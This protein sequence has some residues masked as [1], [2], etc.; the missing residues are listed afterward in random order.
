MSLTQGTVH[1][2][3]FK[4]ILQRLHDNGGRHISCIVILCNL[5]L[6]QELSGGSLT[7]S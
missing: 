7:V 2:L 4:E 6:E 5:R 3:D 1:H